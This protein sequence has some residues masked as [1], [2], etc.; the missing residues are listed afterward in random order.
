MNDINKLFASL[1]NLNL[2]DAVLAQEF[3]TGHIAN[4]LEAKNQ[5]KEGSTDVRKVA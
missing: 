3:L 4:L 1:K 2:D 5:E